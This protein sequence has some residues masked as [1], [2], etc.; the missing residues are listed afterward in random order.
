MEEEVAHLTCALEGGKDMNATIED[1]RRRKALNGSM[2]TKLHRRMIGTLINAT[3]KAK[4]Q[5]DPGW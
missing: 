2:K 5:V 1:G 4:L 3:P